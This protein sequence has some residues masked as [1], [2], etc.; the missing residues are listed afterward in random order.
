MST[1]AGMD[2]TAANSTNPELVLMQVV[3]E[4][5]LKPTNQN[6]EQYRNVLRYVIR[7]RHGDVTALSFVP[8]AEF[9]EFSAWV[10]G[11][12]EQTFKTLQISPAANLRMTGQR[13]V[14]INADG[15]LHG[16]EDH[17]YQAE[18]IWIDITDW[19]SIA[20]PLGT[21]N[22]VYSKVASSIN[23]YPELVSIDIQDERRTDP[24]GGDLE[25]H[26][27][28]VRATVAE[29]CKTISAVLPYVGGYQV[30]GLTCSVR[31]S[32][33]ALVLDP[34]DGYGNWVLISQTLESEARHDV[35]VDTCQYVSVGTW[36]DV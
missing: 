14:G 30:A 33:T 31:G 21:K 20:T 34:M 7:K 9:D 17:E 13:L 11:G 2:I 12:V 1:S 19:A 26:R 23:P 32:S 22:I 15:S 35:V 25:Q 24:S 8:V 4:T 16:E 3:F 29:R 6:M 28:I 27:P 18:S 10:P 36:E 5:R